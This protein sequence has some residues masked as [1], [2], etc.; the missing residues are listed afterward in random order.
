M[1]ALLNCNPQRKNRPSCNKAIKPTSKTLDANIAK[2]SMSWFCV[3]LTASKSYCQI[4]SML[5]TS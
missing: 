5:I 3:T 4:L 1:L 2:T